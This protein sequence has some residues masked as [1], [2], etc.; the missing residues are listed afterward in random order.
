MKIGIDFD[1]TIIDYGDLFYKCA[2]DMFGMPSQ[3]IA[4]KSAIRSYF[5][6]LPDG[7]TLW[8]ELQGIVY[9]EK[10]L[11]AIQPPG[12]DEFLN[13]CNEHQI[14]WC[15]ISHKSEFPAIG[16]KVKL[17]DA[18]FEWLTVNGF[19]SSLGYGLK[20]S[21]VFFETT[22]NSKIMRIKNE[23]C[24]LFI[25]DLPDIFTDVNFPA[26]TIKFLYT[27]DHFTSTN[28][29]ICKDWKSIITSICP[30]INKLYAGTNQ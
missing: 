15:I 23:N 7:N 19:F 1:N 20:R 14:P 12:L 6:S 27:K 11:E 25:D 10:I 26:N 4:E 21:S 13:F 29:I 18:A 17:R 22:K 28:M 3:I 30:L 16:T 5:W 24:T 2:I 9:G 8:T